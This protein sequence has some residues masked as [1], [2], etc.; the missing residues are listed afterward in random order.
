MAPY[1]ADAQLAYLSIKG[2]VDVVISED[3]DLL[4]FGSHKVLFKM[5][6]SGY[7]KLIELKD[8]GK[9]NKTLVVNREKKVGEEW[10]QE[11]RW[12]KRKSIGSDVLVWGRKGGGGLGGMVWRRSLNCGCIVSNSIFPFS[13]KPKISFIF[14]LCVCVC[15][16][17]VCVCACMRG[18]CMCRRVEGSGSGNL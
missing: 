5:D 6:E 9:A 17:V 4:V 15:A 13:P 8:L 7:G 18:V 14:K 3:S 2:I 11:G 1:E 12:E 10:R 16:C